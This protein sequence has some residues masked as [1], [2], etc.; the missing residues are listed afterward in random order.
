MAR[1]NQAPLE[2]K[3]DNRSSHPSLPLVV[4]VVVAEEVST[5]PPP[6]AL[7]VAAED[8]QMQ[9]PQAIYLPQVQV[10]E[11]MAAVPIRRERPAHCALLVAVAV[12]TLAQ[13]AMA[14]QEPL[15]EMA[16]PEHQTASVEPQL[17]MREAVEA[18]TGMTRDRP[19]ILA[20]KAA[21]EAGEMVREM[22]L[23]H[24]QERR[25]EEAVA[26]AAL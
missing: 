12:D 2:A 9:E 24:Q 15:A 16:V 3:A 21:L 22:L 8:R 17:S 14:P 10:R 6:E 18:V 4:V 11:I 20:V 19:H 13:E 5:S 1:L 7:E 26:A 25:I 23:P